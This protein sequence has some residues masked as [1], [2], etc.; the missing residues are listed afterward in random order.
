MLGFV[1]LLQRSPKLPVDTLA[2]SRCFELILWCSAFLLGWQFRNVC[3]DAS[4]VLEIVPH[5]IVPLN[6]IDQRFV[7]QVH[8]SKYNAFVILGN[9]QFSLVGVFSM[10]LCQRGVAILDY[11]L[12]L[13]R[14]ELNHAK[15]LPYCYE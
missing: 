12:V 9:S 5:D 11:E 6:S 4:P 2:V 7:Q 15:D 13:V 3:S 14:K 8:Y 10:N 1:G